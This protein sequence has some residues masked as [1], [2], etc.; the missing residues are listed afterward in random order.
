M[1]TR[2][3]IFIAFLA[4]KVK[5]EQLIQIN[6]LQFNGNFSSILYKTRFLLP[7]YSSLDISVNETNI[8]YEFATMQAHCHHQQISMIMEV[9]PNESITQYGTNIGFLLKPDP[10]N[11]KLFKLM[12]NNNDDVYCLIALIAYPK[13]S[14]MPGNCAAH[15]NSTNIQMIK[16]I[17]EPNL[18][19]SIIPTVH[20]DTKSCNDVDMTYETY[21]TYIDLMDFGFEAYFEAIERVIYDSITTAYQAKH[22]PIHNKHLFEKI[23]GRAIIIN[24]V[25]KGKNGKMAYFVPIASYSCPQNTWSSSCKENNFVKRGFSVVL[26]LFS[27]VMIFNLMGPEFIESMLNGMLFGGFGTILLIESYSIGLQG[28]DYFITVIIGSFVVAAVLGL[29]TIYFE[30]GQ[31]LSKFTLGLFF[32]IFVMEIFFDSVTSVYLEVIIAIILSIILTFVPMTCAVFLGCLILN[33]NISFLLKFGN[34][35]RFMINNFLALTTL[36]AES[37]N[38]SYFDF[39]RPNY[40][41]YKVSLNYVDYIM[42]VIYIVMSIYFTIR[43][44]KFFFVHPEA[45]RQSFMEREVQRM[46]AERDYWTELRKREFVEQYGAQH[47]G[48]YGPIKG[49]TGHDIKT[50]RMCVPNEQ[51]RK[52]IRFSQPTTSDRTPLLINRRTS[53]VESDSYSTPPENSSRPEHFTSCENLLKF[54]D[55]ENGEA[56]G[57]G[58]TTGSRGNH[59]T[60][61]NHGNTSCYASPENRE[62]YETPERDESPDRQQRN[63]S[64]DEINVLGSA[65]I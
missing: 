35:H 18:L 33:L 58:E 47:E 19:T 49:C 54:D 29:I 3:L 13:S 55:S 27:I 63:K 17:E 50:I 28:I 14:P 20:N 36:P 12:N 26:I 60:T 56:S 62:T 51:P 24:T 1:R 8:N 21:Y 2:I 40:I 6:D 32:V 15:V 7:K 48:R 5:C 57:S 38:E 41:N 16:L 61:I 53:D 37:I 52:S 9:S 34:L 45:L 4:W 23:P 31:Y 22:V 43:K 39:I 25:I 30:I 46:E 10:S 59:E 42:L 44:E 64:Y 11:E 65:S